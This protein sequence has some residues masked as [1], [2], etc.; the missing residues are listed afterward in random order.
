M[1]W[2][3]PL[4]HHSTQEPLPTHPPEKKRLHPPETSG[5]IPV[6]HPP[7]SPKPFLCDEQS[8]APS[9]WESRAGTRGLG[10]LWVGSGLWDLAPPW[11]CANL[12]LPANSLLVFPG[13][14]A[15]FHFSCLIF[16]ANSCRVKLFNNIFS[17]LQA[18]GETEPRLCLPLPICHFRRSYT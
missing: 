15:G 9:C 2:E 4:C 14:L 13:T 3:F 10:G 17:G 18:A 5:F 1:G 16:L 8:Q 12:L 6:Q 11:G 7:T